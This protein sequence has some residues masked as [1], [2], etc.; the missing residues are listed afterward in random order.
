[1]RKK[2]TLDCLTV[3]L[4]SS[5]AHCGGKSKF[6]FVL[7]VTRIVLHMEDSMSHHKTQENARHLVISYNLGR[8]NFIHV[9]QEKHVHKY[10]PSLSGFFFF[11]EEYWRN[12]PIS[13]S[14]K[15]RLVWDTDTEQLKFGESNIWQNIY[16]YTQTHSGVYWLWNKFTSKHEQETKQDLQ[17]FRLLDK[18]GPLG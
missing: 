13:L 7:S 18:T 15:S 11:F 6:Y 3:F 9:E 16:I 14:F 8:N 10:Y 2:N 5:E 12:T 1:M 17:T 4:G